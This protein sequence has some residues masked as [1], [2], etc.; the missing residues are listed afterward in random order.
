VDEFELVEQLIAEGKLEPRLL[1]F[2]RSLIQ[3]YS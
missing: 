1:D 3:T 2:W